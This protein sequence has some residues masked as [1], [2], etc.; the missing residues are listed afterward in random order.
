M[1]RCAASLTLAMWCPAPQWN[2][3]SKEVVTRH[4]PS[5]WELQN[6]KSKIN[7]SLVCGIILLAKWNDV[8]KQHL[9]PYAYACRHCWFFKKYINQVI[10]TH[11]S[12][13]SLLPSHKKWLFYVCGLESGKC[14]VEMF[15]DLN[16]F[17]FYS[18]RANSKPGA[19]EKINLLL[20]FD[21]SLIVP[22][23]IRIHL[24]IF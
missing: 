14:P 21:Y 1:C 18:D 3:A 23:H 16:L 19:G 8:K 9:F 22:P 20:F 13:M 7:L 2:S 12:E 17:L 24:I 10:C 15:S 5:T 4:S 6:C 11:Y